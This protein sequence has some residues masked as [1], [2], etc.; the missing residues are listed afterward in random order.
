MNKDEGKNLNFIQCDLVTSVK[1]CPSG[2][3]IV[4]VNSKVI[5]KSIWKL[6]SPRNTKN[7]KIIVT[8]VKIVR[9]NL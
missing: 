2:C 8:F 6:V 7:V 5:L 1:E 3:V 9:T 4:N